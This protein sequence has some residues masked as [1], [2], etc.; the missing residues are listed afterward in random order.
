MSGLA[1][2]F[3]AGVS[4]FATCFTGSGAA[5]LLSGRSGAGGTSGFLGSLFASVFMETVAFFSAGFSAGFSTSFTGA[6]PNTR[7]GRR[8]RDVDRG[9]WTSTELAADENT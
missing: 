4:A 6:G 5:V 7:A 3:V 2:A 8:G 1:G 9:T